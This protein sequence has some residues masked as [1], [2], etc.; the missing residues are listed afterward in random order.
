MSHWIKSFIAKYM[1]AL[2]IVSHLIVFVLQWL[3]PITRWR[4]TECGN[5]EGKFQ[6]KSNKST[7]LPLCTAITIIPKMSCIFVVHKCKLHPI[8]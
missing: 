2:D 8:F 7:M 3:T 5:K 6:T 4:K 1:I